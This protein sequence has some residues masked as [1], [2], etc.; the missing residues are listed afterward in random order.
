[1][2]QI[3]GC[4]TNG[5]NREHLHVRA[6][7]LEIDE[8]HAGQRID[9]FLVRTFPSVPKSHIYRLLRSGQVRVDGRRVKPNRKLTAGEVLRIPPIRFTERDAVIR[10]PD[11]IRNQLSD[12]I[13]FEDNDYVALSKPAG[14]AVHGG[15]GVPYGVIEVARSWERYPYLELA[16][17]LDRDTSGVLLLAKSR[18]ALVRAHACL[19]DGTAK[20]W[21]SALLS[22]KT[23]FAMRDVEASLSD[24]RLAGGER[25]VTIS[26]HGG[27][28][29][30]TRFISKA[31][32]FG[33]TLCDVQIYS[34]R[35]HQIRVHASAIGYAVAGDPRYSSREERRK[36]RDLGLGRMFL[37]A[38]CLKLPAANF[39]DRAFPLLEV[40]APLPDELDSFLK[41]LQAHD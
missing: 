36:F 22:G 37:H 8:R 21:Y 26:N 10:P 16:H 1:M 17:R 5:G 25:V 2:T 20:K 3:S 28:V 13:I 9:N 12:A 32:Y 23:D 6:S 7:H 41:I 34:G 15:S 27:R 29:A 39:A 30:R 35:T 38:R 40:A 11:A 14:V 24:F 4:S 31:R 18:A 19:R 33:A